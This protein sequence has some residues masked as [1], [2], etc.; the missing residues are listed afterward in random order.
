LVVVLNARAK[1]RG[2][3]IF[4]FNIASAKIKLNLTFLPYLALYYP[5]KPFIAKTVTIKNFL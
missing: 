5:H 2:R 4:F 3:D 1:K